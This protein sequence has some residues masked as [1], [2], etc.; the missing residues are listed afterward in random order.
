MELQRLFINKGSFVLGLITQSLKL[1]YK[2]VYEIDI[3]FINFSMSE[4]SF[5][6]AF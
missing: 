2:P 4:P 5:S 3:I 1:N 6:V